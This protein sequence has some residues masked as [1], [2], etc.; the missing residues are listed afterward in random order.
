MYMSTGA[1]LMIL[2]KSANAENREVFANNIDIFNGIDS[3]V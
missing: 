3:E 1:E 2:A